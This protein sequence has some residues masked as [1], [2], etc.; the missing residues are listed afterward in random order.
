MLPSSALHPAAAKLIPLGCHFAPSHPLITPLL[1]FPFLSHQVGSTWLHLEGPSK[2]HFLYRSSLIHR[3][4]HISALIGHWCQLRHSLVNISNKHF[5]V[6]SPAASQE[7]AA[8]LSEAASLPFIRHPWKLSLARVPVTVCRQWGCCQAEP[9]VSC[10]AHPVSN[11]FYL[12]LGWLPLFS[13]C[14]VFVLFSPHL[15]LSRTKWNGI[16]VHDS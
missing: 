2:L 5:D 13:C 16:L 14:Q 12:L 9:A 11:P 15:T 1:A 4:C 10:T 8:H 7:L 3:R 6:F